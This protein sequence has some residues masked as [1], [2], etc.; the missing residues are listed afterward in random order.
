MLL[1]PIVENAVNHGLFHKP[2][3]GKVKI[4]IKYL[5]KE[6]FNISI[7]DDGIG[8]KK[9]KEIYK[10]SSK[11]YQSHSTEVLQERLFLLKQSK[12]W[13]I[14]YKIRD[15]SDEPLKSGTEVNITFKQLL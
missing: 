8:I 13:Q 9:A 10:K 3:K 4:D 12:E 5:D 6:M 1:Q 11:N 15:L 2:D 7:L 14:D